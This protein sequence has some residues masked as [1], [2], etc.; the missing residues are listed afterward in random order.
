MSSQYSLERYLAYK[1]SEHNAAARQAPADSPTSVVMS[2]LP[3]PF[4]IMKTETSDEKYFGR[5]CAR[6]GIGMGKRG[7]LRPLSCDVCAEL[8]HYDCAGRTMAPSRRSWCCP[9]CEGGIMP[10]MPARVV[11]KRKRS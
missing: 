4:P 7:V 1:K 6:C 11:V 8:W 9:R 5:P 2:D 10:D 3:N